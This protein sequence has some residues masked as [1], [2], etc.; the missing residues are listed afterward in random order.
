LIVSAA[1]HTIR[2]ALEEWKRL[3]PR[4]TDALAIRE[5]R[6]RVSR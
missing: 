4:Q 5:T 2:K 3:Q 1:K 6:R